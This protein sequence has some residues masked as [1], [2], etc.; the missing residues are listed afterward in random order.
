MVGNYPPARYANRQAHQQPA[1][2]KLSSAPGVLN[3]LNHAAKVECPEMIFPLAHLLRLG[4]PLSILHYLISIIFKGLLH[5]LPRAGVVQ[6]TRYAL[7]TE[8]PIG[9]LPEKRR[10]NY[11]SNG[12]GYPDHAKLRLG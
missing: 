2:R 10:E 3:A 5:T 8:S 7:G 6:K 11:G 12:T 1:S 4:E 9:Y